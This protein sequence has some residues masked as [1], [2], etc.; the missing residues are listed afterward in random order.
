[1]HFEIHAILTINE[2]N[3]NVLT[4]DS[5]NLHNKKISDSLRQFQDNKKTG[6]VRFSKKNALTELILFAKNIKRTMKLF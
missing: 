3:R 6:Y 4:I 2:C 1:M 5:G